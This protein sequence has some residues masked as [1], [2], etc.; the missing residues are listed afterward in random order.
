MK[1]LFFVLLFSLAGLVNA[2]TAVPTDK[3]PVTA[4][5][6]LE[7]AQQLRCLVCQNQTIADSN[8]GLAV[9]LRQQVREQIAAGRSDRE[10][11]NFM[12]DRYG[13]FVLYQPPFKATTVLL[14]VGPLLLLLIGAFVVLRAIRA[15]RRTAAAP[16]S[17]EERAR[18]AA[19]LGGKESGQ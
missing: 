12:T 11:I 16:L 13:D 5:R 7:I 8:A 2:N 19:L 4:R 15:R 14:W 3:D 10:I 6:E 1:A 18:A 9:D 17:D